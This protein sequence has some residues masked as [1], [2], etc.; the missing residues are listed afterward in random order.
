M[1]SR[2]TQAETIGDLGEFPLISL[3]TRNLTLP[4][5]VSVWPGDD[6]A[7]YLINGSA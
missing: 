4:P 5:A 2:S 3:I 7:A 6:C 1:T